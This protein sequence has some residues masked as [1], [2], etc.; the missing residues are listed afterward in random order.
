MCMSN[1]RVYK[2]KPISI[3]TKERERDAYSKNVILQHVAE[4]KIN[5][6]YAK[7]DRQTRQET[8]RLIGIIKAR[9]FSV[10]SH[11]KAIS[12]LISSQP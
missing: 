11:E 6:E 8:N 4:E 9:L 3:C 12:A 5:V 7:N 10:T 2:K 1:T